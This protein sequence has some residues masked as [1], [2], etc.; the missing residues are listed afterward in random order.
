MRCNET[1][2][3]NDVLSFHPTK[4]CLLDQFMLLSVEKEAHN[5]NKYW[6]NVLVILYRCQKNNLI[7]VLSVDIGSNTSP[8]S[9][10]IKGHCFVFGNNAFLVISWFG[11]QTHDI[12]LTFSTKRDWMVGLNYLEKKV[13]HHTCLRANKHP[14]TFEPCLIGNLVI[15]WRV[16]AV[17]ASKWHSIVYCVQ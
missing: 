6:E 8:G 4:S 5:W 3:R 7:Y 16:H 2:L 1:K 13:G 11:F 17:S 12:F 14:F 15:L 10:L 9:L